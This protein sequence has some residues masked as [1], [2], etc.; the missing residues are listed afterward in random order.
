MLGEGLALPELKIAGLHDKHKSE[1]VT[2]Q[3]VGRFTRIRTDLGDA[4]VI[5]NI[6][7]DKVAAALQ[8]LY[9]EDADWNAILSVVGAKLTE[10]EERREALFQG[11]SEE[12]EGFPVSTLF[13]RMSTVVYRTT[14]DAWRPRAVADAITKSSSIVDGP[15]VNDEARLVLFVT[16]DDERL[17][18]TTLKHPQ[19]VSFN[20]YLAHWDDET[21]LLYINSSKMSDLHL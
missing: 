11:F 18:W 15:V 1:A 10:R 21:G 4:T 16:R 20:L 2:L 6:A 8:S 5:A 7:H 14:C 13:P 19:N 17:R 12:F 9:A 3:F